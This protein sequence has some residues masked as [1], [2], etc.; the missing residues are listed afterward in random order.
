MRGDDLTFPVR[1]YLTRVAL[2]ELSLREICRWGRSEHAGLYF[3]Y[4]PSA[5][6]GCCLT[7]GSSELSTLLHVV[8]CSCP[9]LSVY[10]RRSPLWLSPMAQL[11]VGI[12]PII[13]S[14]SP[15]KTVISL[16]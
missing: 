13:H 16:E 15:T 11:G 7:G 2:K 9:M 8:L 3:D 10:Q 6:K 1:V 5:I 12:G 14:K 4:R